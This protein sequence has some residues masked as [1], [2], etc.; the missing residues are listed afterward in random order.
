MTGQIQENSCG[1]EKDNTQDRER[2]S[3]HM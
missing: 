3:L 1:G 2:E